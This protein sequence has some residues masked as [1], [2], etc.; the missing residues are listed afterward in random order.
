L[1]IIF[2]ERIGSV[3]YHLDLPLD[4]HIHPVV[5]VSFLRPYY[6]GEPLPAPPQDLLTDEVDL[7]LKEHLSYEEE[8]Q[9]PN[10]GVSGEK[11]KEKKNTSFGEENPKNQTV[12][13]PFVSPCIYV[14]YLTPLVRTPLDAT[15]LPLAIYIVSKLNSERAK[16]PR[17][18]KTPSWLK[19]F[20]RQ[21]GGTYS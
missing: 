4:S 18:S 20:Y 15:T 21:C 3:A 12:P 2:M 19:D 11:E 13:H 8:K 5:H 1:K 9:V 10:Q 6:G 17:E 14:P 7:S 16:Y